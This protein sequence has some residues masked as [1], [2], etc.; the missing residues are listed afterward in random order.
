MKIYKKNAKRYLIFE[1]KKVLYHDLTQVSD[2]LQLRNYFYI[3][4]LPLEFWEEI[5]QPGEAD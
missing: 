2:F 3:I 1:F 4:P 5:S